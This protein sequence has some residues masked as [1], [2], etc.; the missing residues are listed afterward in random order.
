MLL[1]L[2]FALSALTGHANAIG[3]YLYSDAACSTQTSYTKYALDVCTTTTTGGFTSS[4]LPTACN[5]T[6]AQAK[7]YAG[8][9]CTGTPMSILTNAPNT[10]FN[11]GGVYVKIVCTDPDQKSVTSSATSN[12]TGWLIVPNVVAIILVAVFNQMIANS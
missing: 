5:A 3:L 8:N 7:T 12:T 4:M 11:D 6:T 10:C 1:Y 9:A 2:L